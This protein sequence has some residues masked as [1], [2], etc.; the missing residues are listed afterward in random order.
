MSPF[1]PVVEAGQRV[2]SAR[3]LVAAKLVVGE[4]APLVHDHRVVPLVGAGGVVGDHQRGAGRTVE[5]TLGLTAPL[6]ED[7]DAAVEEGRA[8][9][10]IVVPIFPGPVD[11]VGDVEDGRFQ[12][13]DGVRGHVKVDRAA[14]GIDD[15]RVEAVEFLLAGLLDAGDTRRTLPDFGADTCVEFQ[16]VVQEAV[17]VAE[18]EL[19][20]AVG[21]GDSVAVRVVG[22]GV[23]LA[24]LHQ[25]VVDGHSA[26]AYIHIAGR[27]G[28]RLAF[29]AGQYACDVEAALRHVR[30]PGAG[31]G[32]GV[33]FVDWCAG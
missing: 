11:T 7:G 10:Q 8:V 2:G 15:T 18:A 13:V 27:I 22:E 25:N 19:E 26:A 21:I 3:V 12:R 4:V 30:A 29:A 32:H 23:L 17:I 33:R 24:H 28:G 14:L 31:G 16:L 9:A 20:L 6:P 5:G 1:R